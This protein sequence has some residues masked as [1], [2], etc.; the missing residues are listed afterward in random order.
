MD[1]HQRRQPW[2]PAP[3]DPPQPA[4]RGTGLLPLLLPAAGPAGRPGQRRRPPLDHRGEFPG[5]P[6]PGRPGRAPGPPL[7]LLG[8]V[9]HPGHARRRRPHHRS[10]R[11]RPLP[12]PRRADPADPQRDRTYDLQPHQ[13][14][15]SRRQAPHA[16]VKMAAL[17]P[18]PSP[19][20]PLPATTRP[21]VRNIAIYG[22]STNVSGVG[23]RK[24]VFRVLLGR[25]SRATKLETTYLQRRNA[26][27]RSL[28]VC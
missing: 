12:G 10:R 17:P 25:T 16:L 28:Y 4:Q 3:A 13:Q 19:D 2:I 26:M 21:R 23:Y 20:L 9:G 15:P 6:G 22:W 27:V 14:P 24:T 7:D 5:W 18:A 11:V 8:P 1:R